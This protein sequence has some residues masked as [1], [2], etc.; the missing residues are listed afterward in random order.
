MLCAEQ[1]WW[2]ARELKKEYT[3]NGVWTTPSH[4]NSLRGPT[5]ATASY[6]YKTRYITVLPD[7]YVFGLR[8]QILLA[9]S[10][11]SK[12]NLDLEKD[13]TVP[14]KL[15]QRKTIFLI[16]FLFVSMMKIAGSESGSGS[17]SQRQ[18]S[19]GSGSGSTKKNVMDPQH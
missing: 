11:N 7:P 1:E 16:I 13:S 3:R 8:I 17:I 6:P 2:K 14:S 18:G 19:C 9:L 5:W 12:K 10:K 15:I 4:C